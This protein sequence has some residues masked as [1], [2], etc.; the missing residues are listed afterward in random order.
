MVG[1]YAVLLFRIA[2]VV[3]CIGIVLYGLLMYWRKTGRPIPSYLLNTAIAVKWTSWTL[4]LLMLLLA[5]WPLDRS[6][7][8]DF[9]HSVNRLLRI[10]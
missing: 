8:N 6:P 2:V 5:Y 4:F 10:F 3:A 1:L 9:F 7:I